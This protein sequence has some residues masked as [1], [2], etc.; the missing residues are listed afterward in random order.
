MN[1][2]S[3]NNRC[4][5]LAGVANR[6]ISLQTRRVLVQLMQEEVN[7]IGK[8]HVTCKFTVTIAQKLHCENT[9]WYL[10]NELLSPWIHC[11]G[12]TQRMPRLKVK[13]KLIYDWLT[14]SRKLTSTWLCQ[15]VSM[16]WYRVHLWDLRPDIISCPN[17]TLWNFRSCIW[18]RPLWREYGSAICSVITQWSES[19]RT[20]NRILLPHLRLP[21]PGGPGSRILIPQEQGGLVIPTGTGFPL[22]R[23]LRL[24]SYDSQ[25]YDGG[26]RILPLPGC[27]DPCIYSLQK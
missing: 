7:F 2:S 11:Y 24:A 26:I 22:H 14:V 13:S 17:V 10:G 12:A 27:T 6:I 1:R 8:R 4:N 23:L 21:Q 25:G 3:H 18:G 16:S 9:V 19:L 15:S 5:L 20:R